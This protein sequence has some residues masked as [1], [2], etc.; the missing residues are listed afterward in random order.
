V[1]YL[2]TFNC[3]GSHLRGDDRGSAD[4][5]REGRGGPIEPSAKLVAFGERNMTHEAAKLDL[6][7]ALVVL[8]AVRETC[9]FRRWTLLAAHVRHTHAH[10]VAD[11][12]ADPKSAI[13]DFKT[14]ASRMLNRDGV[15]RRW[16]RGGNARLL[17]NSGAVRAAVRYVVEGQG[18]PMAVHIAPDSRYGPSLGMFD[19]ANSG[20]GENIR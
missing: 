16:A 19:Y 13:R 14:Y 7:Q 4:R 18:W 15:R 12:I 9:S 5:I 8:D 11:G 2:L 3:Y 10:I 6:H 17:G 20:S 1:A